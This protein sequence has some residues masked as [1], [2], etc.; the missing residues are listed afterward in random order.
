MLSL[1]QLTSSTKTSVGTF[2]SNARMAAGKIFFAVAVVC[3]CVMEVRADVSTPFSNPLTSSSY[4]IHGIKHKQ[5]LLLSCVQ[6]SL[7]YSRACTSGSERALSVLFPCV[8]HLLVECSTKYVNLYASVPTI[9]L[10]PTLPLVEHESGWVRG[11]FRKSLNPRIR[12]VGVVEFFGRLECA[13]ISTT[14]LSIQPLTNITSVVLSVTRACM[15]AVGFV[16]VKHTQS[17]E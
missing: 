3:L 4:R 11:L 12:V 10:N 16:R 8:Q 13:V 15:V 1:S 6:T 9:S 14:N 7:Q 5:R 2:E 17:R